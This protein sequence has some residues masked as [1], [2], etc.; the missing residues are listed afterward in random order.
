MKKKTERINKYGHS[1]IVSEETAKII[2]EFN[3]EPGKVTK[4]DFEKPVRKIEDISIEDQVEYLDLMCFPL[5]GQSAEE[6]AKEVIDWTYGISPRK[7]E[8]YTSVKG[9]NLDQLKSIQSFILEQI[10]YNTG[11]KRLPIILKVIDDILLKFNES[12][13]KKKRTKKYKDLMIIGRE[14]ALGKLGELKSNGSIELN[15]SIPATAKKLGVTGEYLR[16]TAFDYSDENN[17][18]KNLK[19]NPEIISEIIQEIES[20]SNKP[21]PEFLKHFK[22]L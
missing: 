11:N 16:A 1:I 15:E 19:Y 6:R 12:S 20:E 9:F 4:P 2:N 5:G 3:K 18:R 7:V 14:I 13:N 22:P 21:I 17:K 8:N 10:I